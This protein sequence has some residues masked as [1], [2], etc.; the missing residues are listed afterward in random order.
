M[1]ISLLIVYCRARSIDSQI[2][3]RRD[4]DEI[5]VQVSFSLSLRCFLKSTAE[6]AT[7]RV[8]VRIR[9]SMMV[10]IMV[11]IIMMARILRR[12]LL[13]LLLLRLRLLRLLAP[14]AMIQVQ[15]R[16]ND[17][18][19]MMTLILCTS[20]FIVV[21]FLIEN[22]LFLKTTLEHAT[23]VVKVVTAVIT[24]I[25]MIRSNND[26][27]LMM[28]LILSTSLF[29][30]VEF[31]IENL[32]FLKT[33]LE[34]ATGGIR[35]VAPKVPKMRSNS[36]SNDAPLMMTMILI[37]CTSL[38]IVVEFLIEIFLFLKTT[39][40]HAPVIVKELAVSS[41]SSRS[42]S[43]KIPLP[44]INNDAPLMMILILSTSRFHCGRISYR[45]L[46]RAREYLYLD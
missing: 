5:L 23:G 27:P 11:I 7:R 44:V 6:H 37:L 24:I 1:I 2:L 31:L 42:S 38:F 36:N 13:R 18:P 16:S 8:R 21:E 28:M 12:L 4:L 3:R 41:V 33:T 15:L 26:D 32:L 39:L 22:L 20:L 43:S 10:S 17:A 9:V 40:E 30:V 25:Q 34:H 35:F 45:K 29:I 14:L 19:L 46:F